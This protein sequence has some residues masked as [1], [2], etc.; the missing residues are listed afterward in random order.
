MGGYD[1]VYFNRWDSFVWTYATTFT[2]AAEAMV[3]EEGA[4]ADGSP[5]YV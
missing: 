5:S 2:I 3:T 4:R 1:T